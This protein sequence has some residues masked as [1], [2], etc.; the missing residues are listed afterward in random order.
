MA[1][2]ARRVGSMAYGRRLKISSSSL[3]SLTSW[4]LIQLFRFFSFFFFSGKCI[5]GLCL[6]GFDAYFKALRPK[7]A[8]VCG[9][10]GGGGGGGGGGAANNGGPAGGNGAGGGMGTGLGGG[11]GYG[12]NQYYRNAVKG[13]RIFNCRNPWFR[14]FWE[15]HFKCRFNNS[16]GTGGTAS[17]GTLPEC[18]GGDKL[19][20]YEQE[21]LVPFVG[22]FSNVLENA[23]KGHRL[24]RTGV[25]D[26]GSQ[27]HH[28]TVNWIPG[29]ETL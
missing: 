8:K 2:L 18:R 19:T 25:H 3:N 11:S 20:Y 26:T 10:V 29:A 17:N 28:R 22:K 4:R 12:E 24:R 13:S 21:G 23:G 9:S 1:I 14:Q 7:T 27:R 15:Q 6:V 16:S 5:T